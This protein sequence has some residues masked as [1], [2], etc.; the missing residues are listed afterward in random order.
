[1]FRWTSKHQS[2]G[3][4]SKQ[5]N[6]G[7]TLWKFQWSWIQSCL[8]LIG[9]IDSV[10]SFFGMVKTWNLGLCWFCR[11]LNASDP[12]SKLQENQFNQIIRVAKEVD[13][14]SYDTGLILHGG[15]RGDCL[16]APW[17]LPRC[18]WNVLLVESRRFEKGPRG[19]LLCPF[20]SAIE[21]LLTNWK[22]VLNYNGWRPQSKL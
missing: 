8:S 7:R 9:N 16:Q 10:S 11:R 12:F 1:M 19:K 21:G 20:M 17:S 14:A 4:N 15:N 18:P 6:R 22:S 13:Q 3:G 2:F 5:S